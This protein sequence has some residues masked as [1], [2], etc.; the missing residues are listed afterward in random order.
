MA[1][2]KLYNG[3]EIPTIGLGT[4]H[5]DGEVLTKVVEAQIKT[6]CGLIDTASAYGNEKALGDS[7]KLLLKK[8][9][10]REHFFIETKVGDKVDEIGRPLGYYFYNNPSTCPCNDTKRI[11]YEQVEN[12]LKDLGLAY[13]DLVMVHWPYYEVLNEIW[14][15]LEELY[16]QKLI[17]VIGVSNC[18]KRHIER[19]L[20]TAK[21]VPMVNQ[22]FI[23]PINTREEDYQY[24]LDNNIRIE[25]YSPLYALRNKDFK[26]RRDIFELQNKYNKDISQILLRWFYQKG[27]I[28]IPKTHRIERITSNNNIYDFSI[29]DN[30]MK[31]IAGA[32]INYQSIVESKYCPGY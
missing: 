8:G 5:T 11:V 14:S 24:C 15:S 25:A 3:V 32:N 22:I 23:S 27:I 18:R 28:P 31:L 16:E 19:I 12:S 26:E 29:D 30:D 10:K 4:F 21:Y 7:L 2:Y 20:R 9:Y 1:H 6:G 13:L 17:R